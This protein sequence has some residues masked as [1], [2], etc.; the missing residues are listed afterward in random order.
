MN[1]TSQ[2]DTLK[3]M[4]LHDCYELTILRIT[5]ESLRETRI[6]CTEPK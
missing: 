1:K 4:I 3:V 2:C 5:L 6:R